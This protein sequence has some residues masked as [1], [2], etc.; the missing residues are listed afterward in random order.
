M[1]SVARLCPDQS[2]CRCVIDVVLLGLVCCT[3]LIRTLTTVG[4]ANFDLLLLEFDIPKQAAAAAHPLEI[5]ESRCR[6]SRFARSF[7]PTLCLTLER[8]MCSRVQSTVGGFLSC[9]FFFRGT[10]ACLS[11]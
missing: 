1:Y 3:R 5:E 7:L 4:S 2:S 10:G 11:L 8:W 6:T 9:V